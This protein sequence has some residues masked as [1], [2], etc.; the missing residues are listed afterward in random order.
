[1]NV[2]I[3]ELLFHESVEIK[4]WT[5]NFESLTHFLWWTSQHPSFWWLHQTQPDS[6]QIYSRVVAVWREP[7]SC[8]TRRAK[9]TNMIIYKFPLF[10]CFW[11]WTVISYTMQPLNYSIN[12][13]LAFSASLEGCLSATHAILHTKRIPVGITWQKNCFVQLNG[14]E[15][16]PISSTHSF[17]T[18][19]SA[20]V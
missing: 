8:E 9:Q 3:C 5:L 6:L 20:L 10:L 11:S 12:I 4:L 17:M 2:I 13:L 15:K 14:F 1:M 18:T 7:L 19:L 16:L